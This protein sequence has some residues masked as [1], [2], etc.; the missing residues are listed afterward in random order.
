MKDVI[1]IEN[2]V[3]FAQLSVTIEQVDSIYIGYIPSFD[4]PFT[5]PTKE[6]A[7]EI[8]KGLINA[9]FK[10][11][12]HLGVFEQKLMQYKFNKSQSISLEQFENIVHKKSFQ[13]KQQVDVV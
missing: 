6:K 10:K 4:L 1:K 7:K 11:W 8:A 3:I 13:F 5:S 12:Y 2:G 9:L